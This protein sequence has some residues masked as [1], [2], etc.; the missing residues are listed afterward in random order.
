MTTEN[1]NYIDYLQGRAL[2]TAPQ[3]EIWLSVRSYIV[4][5]V[6]LGISPTDIMRLNLNYLTTTPK[7][8]ADETVYIW[9]DSL[10]ALIERSVI[11]EDQRFIHYHQTEEYHILFPGEVLRFAARFNESRTTFVC[12]EHGSVFPESYIN[13]PFV[14]ELQWWMLEDYLLLH[15]A[16]VGVNGKGALITASS[17]SGK[18]TLALSGLL[19]G[20]NYL[21]EDYVLVSRRGPAIAYPIFTTGYVTSDTL[22]MLP[23]LKDKILLYVPRRDKYL[24]D[25][26]AFDDL[27]L[28]EIPLSVM[29]FPLVTDLPSIQVE[30]ASSVKPFMD[31]LTTT[32]KQIESCERF[33][34]SF[35]LLFARM[36]TIPSYQLN[37][38]KDTRKNAHEFREFLENYGG[39]KYGSHN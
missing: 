35:K 11:P 20:M 15:G 9:E 19:E 38:T 1:Q 30:K 18:S 22:Q 4:K 14:N 5:M 23:E 7:E 29:V 12:F 26:S 24:I 39:V 3:A 2:R 13:K 25:L 27:F 32:A 31:A 33:A 8:T 28:D 17:G 34:D 16:V 10:D 36:K 21:A 37:L 6:F